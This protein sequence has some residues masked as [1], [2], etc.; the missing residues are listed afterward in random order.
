LLRELAEGLAA[1]RVALAPTGHWR[2]TLVLTYSEF[3]RR[4]HENCSL[5]TDHGTAAPHSFLGGR[6][7]GGWYGRQPAL[8]A[9]RDG[10]LAHHV[11]YRSLYATVARRWWAMAS[12]FLGARAYPLLDCLA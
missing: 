8:D 3:G 5:G 12:D 9:L 10:D 4:A 1:L 6:V 2:R 11:D 7:R